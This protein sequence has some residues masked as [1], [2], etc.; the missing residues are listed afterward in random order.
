MLLKDKVGVCG[1]TG[2]ATAGW[3]GSS[4]G[5]GKF[6]DL[7]ENMTLLKRPPT[8]D[9]VANTAAFLTSDQPRQ[10]RELSQISHAA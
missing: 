3:S 9:D 6:R 8:L 5:A 7:L 1:H 10:L 4:H 2:L